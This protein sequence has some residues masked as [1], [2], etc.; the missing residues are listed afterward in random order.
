MPLGHS[1]ERVWDTAGPGALPGG[2]VVKADGRASSSKL[3][4]GTESLTDPVM[5]WNCF[6]D[7]VI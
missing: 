1:G 3:G 4:P 6:H 2:A 7:N 5:D